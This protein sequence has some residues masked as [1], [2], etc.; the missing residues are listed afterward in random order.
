LPYGLAHPTALD[1]WA[2]THGRP[3]VDDHQDIYVLPVGNAN[4]DGFYN[5]TVLRALDTGDV[6]DAVLP[7]VS[8]YSMYNMYLIGS[9]YNYDMVVCKE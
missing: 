9:K 3:N 8:L 4:S 5:I 6:N 2:N 1:C 7:I